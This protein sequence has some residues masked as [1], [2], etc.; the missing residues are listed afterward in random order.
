MAQPGGG[1]PQCWDIETTNLFIDENCNAKLCE[2]PADRAVPGDE[3][4]KVDTTHFWQDC[5]DCP[6]ELVN[7]NCFI[8]LDNCGPAYMQLVAHDVGVEECSGGGGGVE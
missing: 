5:Q 4:K 3:F 8:D 7:G 1:S 6:G 2:Y